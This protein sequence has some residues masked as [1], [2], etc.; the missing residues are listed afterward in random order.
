MTD[1]Y[2]LDPRNDDVVPRRRLYVPRALLW[3]MLTAFH[4][5]LGHQGY[6]R[7]ESVMKLRYYW[8]G[9]MRSIQEYVGECHECTLAKPPRRR[10]RLPKGPQVGGHE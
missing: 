9:M 8:P 5:H 2:R 3:P 1:F 10:Y 6:T 7:M 4:D